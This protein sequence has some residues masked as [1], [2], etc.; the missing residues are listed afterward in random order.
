MYDEPGPNFKNARELAKMLPHLALRFASDPVLSE[1]HLK[2]FAN[3]PDVDP[4]I[5]ATALKTL[6]SKKQQAELIQK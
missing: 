2:S 4:L 5:R 6:A 3:N 1:A